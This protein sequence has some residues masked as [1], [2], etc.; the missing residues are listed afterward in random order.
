MK[1]SHLRFFSV[2]VVVGLA[3]ALSGCDGR[4]TGTTQTPDKS[5][6]ASG[7]TS[8]VEATRSIGNTTALPA[9][10]ALPGS[11]GSALRGAHRQRIAATVLVLHDQD[12]F[13]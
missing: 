6:P 12:D 2:A 11:S 5:A 1:G 3:T 10:G 8:A 7:S 4:G 9:D 13:L